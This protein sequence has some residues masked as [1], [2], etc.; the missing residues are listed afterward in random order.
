MA[1]HGSW[2]TLLFLLRGFKFFP[3]LMTCL[4]NPVSDAIFILVSIGFLAMVMKHEDS[5]ATA[6][7]AKVLRT[8][9]VRKL[10]RTWVETTF[11]NVNKYI[12]DSATSLSV[13]TNNVN[14]KFQRSKSSNCR[15]YTKRGVGT[16]RLGRLY[17]PYLLMAALQVKATPMYSP[18]PLNVNN[19][20]VDAAPDI[21]PNPNIYSDDRHDEQDYLCFHALQD[22]DEQDLVCYSNTQHFGVPTLQ[23]DSD[24]FPIG[25]DTFASAFMS[26][27]ITDFV[28]GTLKPLPARKSVQAY[29][30]DGPKI[31]V[32]MKGTLKWTVED[33]DSRTHEFRINNSL[34]VP[35]GNMR[36]LSPQHWAVKSTVQQGKQ[37]LRCNIH[38][39]G[40]MQFWNR[41]IL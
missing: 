21:S 27:Q 22:Y 2:K 20:R 35:D 6:R 30:K 1:Y 34:Y 4:N 25:I 31:D 13:N 14:C 18:T 17:K 41:N 28:P 12:E 16:K 40:S 24:S 37:Q 19:A 36:L 38:H 33:N 23:F 32:T 11:E 3:M 8:R 5:E 26:P 15:M 7:I 29:G 9:K 10:V 39:K